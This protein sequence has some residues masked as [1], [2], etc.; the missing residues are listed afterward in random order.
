MNPRPALLLVALALASS[1]A[2]AQPV[3]TLDADPELAVR[4]AETIT[5]SDLAA[6]LYVFASDYFEGRETATRGQK[7]AAQYLAGQYRK[8]GVS[9]KGTA[10]T[11]DPL[12][13][14]AYF[15]PFALTEAYV[16]SAGLT[17]QRGGETVATSTFTPERQDGLAYLRSGGDGSMTGGVV[18]AGYGIGGNEAY[19]D[20]A[21]L[22][23]A[24]LSVAGK[25]VLVLGDEPLSAEGRSLL[26]EDG[27]PTDFS[28]S[29]YR[30]ALGFLRSDLGAPAG[31][32][33]VAD[34]SPLQPLG[35]AEQAAATAQRLGSLSLAGSESGGG[36]RFPAMFNV[37]SD[38][39]NA[40]LASSGR[41]VA[42]LQRAIDSSL[43]PVVF[44]VDDVN[45]E[46]A[47]ERATRTVESEN[48]LAFIE[49]SDPVL[50]D[51]IVVLSSHY[52]HVGMDPLAIGDGIYNGADDDGSGTVT[53]LEIAEAFEQ[54]RRDGHGPRRSVLFLN[55]SGEEKGLL[56][57]A[58]Y[59]DTEPVFPL[60]NTVANL[61]IDMIG[62]YDPELDGA[63]NYVYLIGSKIVSDDLD[64]ISTAANALVGGG[65]ELNDRFNTK[66]DPNQFYRRSDHWNFGKHR[67][68]FVFYF[69]G[70][71]EDYHGVG[72]EAHKIDYE[73][74]ARIGRL[75]FATTWQIANQDARPAISGAGFWDGEG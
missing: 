75:I 29:W 67:I 37:S 20:L 23:D 45:V 16:A 25:W 48:V 24:G 40:I 73:R 19:D 13:P 11:D 65:L 4:Y 32:L 10:A 7:L 56:G 58:Y 66:D 8:I 60:E 21:A 53:I 28:T 17:V 72:D 35:V 68:P 52:D 27:V 44:A 43:I 5:P 36:S 71:H 9:P 57:S 61:N 12:S 63:T 59:A 38:F 30:K 26:T 55:V 39:A 51:E 22:R 3:P 70:T 41:T 34:T 1:A 18:F 15:Q 69:T 6:H 31:F 2:C 49:G 64:R 46:A 33:V 50:K 42:E 62:R 54:A 47:V 74:M 14:A